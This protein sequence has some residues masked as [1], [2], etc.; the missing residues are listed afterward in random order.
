M[1]FTRPTSART[2]SVPTLPTGTQVAVYGT[3]VEAQQAVHYLSADHFPV[4]HITIVGTNLQSVERV[5]GRLSYGRVAIAGAMSGA[6]FGLFVG[7]LLSLFG[8]AG[9]T[10]GI[11]FIAIA[12]GAGFGLLFSVLSY[13]VTRSRRDF[14]SST[15]VVAAQYAILCEPGEAMAATQI[16]TKSPVGV[17]SRSL[18]GVPSGMPV[19]GGVVAGPPTLVAGEPAAGVV[20][21]GGSS[22][23]MVVAAPATVV[24]P[25]KPDSRWVDEDGRPRFG[26]MADDQP[27]AVAVPEQVVVAPPT[28]VGVTEVVEELVVVSTPQPKAGPIDPYAPP[29]NTYRH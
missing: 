26:A 22:P 7:L 28:V 15:Q 16:L 24:E 20:A 3:Y 4:E 18:A 25:R 13:A 29:P 5:T 6:W 9:V 12:L 23:T 27:A 2:V 11:T 14:T 8:G 17:R 1:S 21:G 19:S 10:A